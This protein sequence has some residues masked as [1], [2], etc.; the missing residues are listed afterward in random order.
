MVEADTERVLFTGAI[1]EEPELIGVG[2]G[3]TDI[4]KEGTL[5]FVTDVGSTETVSVE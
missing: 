5:V 2:V 4:L 1:G 3:D